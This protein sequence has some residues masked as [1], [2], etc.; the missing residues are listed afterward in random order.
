M[1][2]LFFLTVILMGCAF[3][4][5][6]ENEPSAFKKSLI[7]PAQSFSIFQWDDDNWYTRVHFLHSGSP[8]IQ[9]TDIYSW[10]ALFYISPDDHWMLQIQKSGS[11]ENISFLFR[12]DPEGRFWQMEPSLMELAWAFIERNQSLHKSD[13]YH[14]GIEFRSWDLQAQQL[15]FTFRGTYDKRSGGID[16]P[17]IYDLK[18]NVISKETKP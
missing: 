9:F 13:L 6:A 3:A 2:T 12:I 17:L 4:L 15:H 16:V 8:D 10:P 18:K 1:R 5:Q 7:S 11:G 14:T